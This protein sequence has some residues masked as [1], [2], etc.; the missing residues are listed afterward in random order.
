MDQFLRQTELP[1]LP[2]ADKVTHEEALA[3]ANEQYDAFAERRRLQVEAA[4]EA[5]YLEDLR[6]S[7]K[8]FEAER[9]KPPQSGK[10][11]GKKR[12]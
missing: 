8:T 3:W 1:V 10:K 2:D 7:A 9:K 5:S 4:A 12:R 6:A 11:R